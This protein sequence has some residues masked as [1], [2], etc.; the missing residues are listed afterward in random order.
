MFLTVKTTETFVLQDPVIQVAIEISCRSSDN[1]VLNA[2]KYNPDMSTDN[3]AVLIKACSHVHY[4]L[5]V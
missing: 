2:N 3:I 1:P 4:L 5:F